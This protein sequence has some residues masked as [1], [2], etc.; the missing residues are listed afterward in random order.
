MALELTLTM[1]EARNDK[2]TEKWNTMKSNQEYRRIQKMD[3][4]MM[5]VARN[6]QETEIWNTMNPNK[7]H[8]RIQKNKENG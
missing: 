1:T 4:L 3:N 7:E 6:E 5:T 2:E 8:R